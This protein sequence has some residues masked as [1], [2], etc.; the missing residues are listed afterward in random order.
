MASER[1]TDRLDEIAER[2][3]KA[4]K[5]PWC[6]TAGNVVDADYEHTVS[7]DSSDADAI[8]IAAA[9]TDIAWLIE[10]VRRADD[11]I[12]RQAEEP[13]CPRD[14]DGDERRAWTAFLEA[15]GRG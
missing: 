15:R 4:T 3:S 2:W 10:C 12:A 11:V 14:C 7:F 8:A 1:V 9:P 6:A 5:G 13:P